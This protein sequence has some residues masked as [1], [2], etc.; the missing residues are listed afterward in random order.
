MSNDDVKVAVLMRMY[1]VPPVLAKF[2]VR[3]ILSQ[4]H[5]NLRLYVYNDGGKD[6][7]DW[8]D[9]FDD[10]RIVLSGSDKN[11]GRGWAAN[12]LLDMVDDDVDCMTFCDA[13]GDQFGPSL[14]EESLRYVDLLA[15][16]D[17]WWVRPIRSYG[18]R[19]TTNNMSM[20]LV[21]DGFSMGDHLDENSKTF[22]K[23]F[24]CRVDMFDNAL[25]GCISPLFLPAHARCVR[26]DDFLDA[27]ED[28]GWTRNLH[29]WALEN[30]GLWR[31]GNCSGSSFYGGPLA[32]D[33]YFAPVHTKKYAGKLSASK[34]YG[35]PIYPFAEK[36]DAHIPTKAVVKKFCE[37]HF[38]KRQTMIEV[39]AE[40]D[41][42]VAAGDSAKGD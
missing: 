18:S 42:H 15:D 21:A 23:F 35:S 30:H 20:A 40:L 34:V 19:Q 25:I 12:A 36:L 8:L 24:M 9:A 31:G 11:G 5:R 22:D 6:P 13:D 1:N 28:V 17:F 27:G 2:S 14:I 29:V 37:T 3:S 33:F 7:G 38:E 16:R 26:F 39:L 32:S 41:A 10:D 4:T